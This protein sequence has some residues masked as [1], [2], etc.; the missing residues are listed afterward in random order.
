MEDTF[1]LNTEAWQHVNLPSFIQI[2]TD[3]GLNLVTIEKKVS[4]IENKIRKKPPS[5]RTIQRLSQK[6][7]NLLLH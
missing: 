6:Q 2:N 3:W 5:K 7:K 4:E 1:V